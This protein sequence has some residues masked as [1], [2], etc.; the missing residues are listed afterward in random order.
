MRSFI[1]LIKTTP[2]MI[3]GFMMATSSRYTN[4][5]IGF[6]IVVLSLLYIWVA[7][8]FSKHDEEDIIS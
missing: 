3:L 7:S 1:R 6:T 5:K 8:Q 2:F 4:A